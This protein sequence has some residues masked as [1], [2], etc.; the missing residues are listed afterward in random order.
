M[1]TPTTTYALNVSTGICLDSLW[2]LF[3]GKTACSP[4]QPWIVMQHSM[5]LNSWSFSRAGMQAPTI[6]LSWCCFK[7]Q[8]TDQLTLPRS[9]TTSLAFFKAQ[10]FITCTH[11]IK[12]L[13]KIF[14]VSP[15]RRLSVSPYIHPLSSWSL[16]FTASRLSTSKC[17]SSDQV[18]KICSDCL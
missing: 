2:C 15:T 8:N 1:K 14:L 13:R 12:E 5:A 17:W 16:C 11:S 6:T 7:V 10:L 4:G 9:Q 18:T 3:W